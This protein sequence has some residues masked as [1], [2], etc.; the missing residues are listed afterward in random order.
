M[1]L[2]PSL[3]QRA[4][5]LAPYAALP[6]ILLLATGWA[7]WHKLKMTQRPRVVCQPTAF[8]R[9]VLSRMPTIRA[10]YRPLLFLTNGHVETIFAAKARSKT[11]FR[12]RREY[13]LVP[14]G[15]IVALDWKAPDPQSSVCP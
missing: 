4:V 10:L 5:D 9:G 8:N 1:A 6:L 12:Y 7:W 3:A 15:G 2:D 14:E 13:L 11:L